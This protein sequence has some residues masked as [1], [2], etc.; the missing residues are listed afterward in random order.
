MYYKLDVFSSKITQL[1]LY[2]NLPLF[3]KNPSLFD[4]LLHR[5]T[6]QQVVELIS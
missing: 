4:K 1:M 5:F 2:V 6:V 3:T